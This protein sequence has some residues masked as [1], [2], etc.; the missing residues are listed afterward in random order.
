MNVCY[1]IAVRRLDC[2]NTNNVMNAILLKKYDA[3][4]IKCKA[5]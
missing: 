3:R 1:S 4:F 5:S 2:D